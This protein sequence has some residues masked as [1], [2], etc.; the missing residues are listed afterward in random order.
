MYA[1]HRCSVECSRILLGVLKVALDAVVV[2]VA[3]TDMPL[4][5]SPICGGAACYLFGK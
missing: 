1:L 5:F 2:E 4:C 3:R